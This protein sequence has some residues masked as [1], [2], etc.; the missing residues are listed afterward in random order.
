MTFTQ[1]YTYFATSIARKK[2]TEQ[3]IKKYQTYL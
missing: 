1:F 3:L 2:K